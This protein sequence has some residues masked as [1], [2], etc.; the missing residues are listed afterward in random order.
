MRV[1]GTGNEKMRYQD[2]M[3]FQNGP[4]SIMS[5]KQDHH[6]F[7]DHRWLKFAVDLSH[8]LCSDWTPKWTETR[9]RITDATLLQ[10]DYLQASSPFSL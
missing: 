6:S 4:T 7:L 5:I 1:N 3:I 2:G 8:P 10:A 9:R